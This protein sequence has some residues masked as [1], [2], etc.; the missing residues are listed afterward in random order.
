MN[1]EIAYSV[2]IKTAIEEIPAEKWDALANPS[3]ETYNPFITHAFLKSLEDAGCVGIDEGWAPVH[4]ALCDQNEE[5]LG[6]MPCYLKLHSQGEFVFDHGW[7]N[8]SE[9]MGKRYYPKLQA[10]VPFTPVVGPKLLVA[11]GPEKEQYQKL[12]VSGALQLLEQYE[13]SSLH[14]TFLN[15]SERKLL[16]DMGLLSRTDHQFHWQNNQYNTFDDFLETLSSRKRKGVRKERREAVSNNIDIKWVTGDE[17]T[18][19]HWDAFFQFYI[20]TSMGKWGRVYLNREF[21]SLIGERLADD[22]L[23]ILCEREGRTIAGALNLIGGD[24]L[25]GRYW[26]AIEHHKFLHFETCYYQAIDFAIEKGLKRVEAGAQGQHKLA[27]GYMPATTY[28]A[29][30]IADP[31]LRQAIAYHLEGERE[32]VDKEGAVLSSMAPYAKDK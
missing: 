25:Y 24:C 31:R 30:Y 18:E 28:S 29:H 12:L 5:A 23:L 19:D 2:H 1:E 32:Y 20:D 14:M 6:Y 7:A 17:I 11:E 16:N 8:A 3:P 26:G 21:F 15:P 4:L 22:I 10:A 27:R 13:A 9:Q